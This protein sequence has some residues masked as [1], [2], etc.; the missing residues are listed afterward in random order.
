MCIR[1]R[2]TSIPSITVDAQGRITAASGNTVN[3]DLVGDTSPQLGGHLDTNGKKIN[4]GDSS[5]GSTNNVLYFGAGG[6]LKIFHAP[7]NSFIMETGSGNLKIQASDLILADVDGTEF[8]RGYNNGRVELSNNGSVRLE[9]TSVGNRLYGRTDIGD[10]TGG[11]TDDRLAFG[12]SQDLQIYHNGSNS[13]VANS[14]GQ[15]VLEGDDLMFM[16]SGRTESLARFQ[17]NG[18]VILYHDNS[19][20]LATNSGGVSV[21]NG[22]AVGTGALQNGSVASFVGS[23]SNQINIT[24]GS[25]NGWGLLLSQ[26]QGTTSTNSYHYS[27]NSSVNKPCAVVNVNNDALHFATNNTVRFRIEH[28]GHVLPS[29][30]NNYDLG[31]SSYRWRNIYT[32]DLHLSNEGHS[33]EVDGTWGNWTIQEGE[34]DLFLKNNRS[35]KKYKFNLT[36]VS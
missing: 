17:N 10:S 27:T 35:G 33:N 22:L 24:D 16:N 29:A 30:N 21:Y 34:S 7:E 5:D 3:T 19:Q 18:A 4:F 14:T 12:D 1:D 20:R 31:S 26:S 8:F 15:L 11:S 9:T 23:T 13:Y 25:N 36:E 6:D 2:S 28:D 32:N